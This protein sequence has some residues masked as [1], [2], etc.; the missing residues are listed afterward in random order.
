ML[1]LIPRYLPELSQLISDCGAPS[2]VE[3][4]A[5]LDVSPRTVFRWL[6]AR[7]APRAALLALY[8]V[9][10]YG[11]SAHESEARRRLA[12]WRALADAR[13]AEIDALQARLARFARLADFGSAN[14]PGWRD[15]D[16]GRGPELAANDGGIGVPPIP[17]VNVGHGLVP[18]FLG[19][20]DD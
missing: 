3:L 17:C 20:G 11:W 12:D 10:P 8:W 2:V 5:A 15:G 6:E 14:S 19:P 16:P 13:G 7:A 9:T 1:H 4:S 18:P